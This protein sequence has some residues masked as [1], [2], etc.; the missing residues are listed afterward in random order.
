MSATKWA[1]D[2]A[3]QPLPVA[4]LPSGRDLSRL[5]GRLPGRR[6]VPKRLAG[7]VPR[8]D[9]FCLHSPQRPASASFPSPSRTREQR[10]SRIDEMSDRFFSDDAFS[11]IRLMDRATCLLK[12]SKRRGSWSRAIQEQVLERRMPPWPAATGF[13]DY[14][15]DRSLTPIEIELLAAWADGGAPLGDGADVVTGGQNAT[16]GGIGVDT[17]RGASPALAWSGSPSRRMSALIDGF[18]VGTSV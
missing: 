4:G 18:P 11:V 6:H 17:A 13:A 3:T 5:F 15:N 10:R 12:R 16:D 8:M 7:T 2:R 14:G 9:G 1:H